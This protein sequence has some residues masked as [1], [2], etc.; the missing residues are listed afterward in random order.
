MSNT[1]RLDTRRCF[2]EKYAQLRAL[3]AR[4]LRRHPNVR[5]EP[6]DL[7]HEV[8]LRLTSRTG[9]SLW[10]D[11][12][13]FLKTAAQSMRFA[14]LDLVKH[15]YA[16][17]RR[18]DRRAPD[19]DCDALEDRDAT[20]VDPSWTELLEVLRERP[21]LFDVAESRFVRGE[22]IAQTALRLHLTRKQVRT[23]T[24]KARRLLRHVHGCDDALRAG[25]ISRPKPTPETAL[26]AP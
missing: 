25:R 22:S 17:K 9:S 19:L 10:N 12:D 8:Y 21:R 26:P 16:E 2:R 20:P 14:I 5:I 15:E 13:H 23:A 1:K 6:A 4:R 11:D 18:D 24:A 7:V 3:A